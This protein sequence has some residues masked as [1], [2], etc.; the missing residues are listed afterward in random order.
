LPLKLEQT[1][2]VAGPRDIAEAIRLHEVAELGVDDQT[3]GDEIRLELQIARREAGVHKLPLQVLIGA[4]LPRLDPVVDTGVV[5][6]VAD[7]PDGPEIQGTVAV[8]A[9]PGRRV[10]RQLVLPCHVA[11]LHAA[12]N[13]LLGRLTTRTPPPSRRAGW[14][15]VAA[16]RPRT[17]GSCPQIPRRAHERGRCGARPGPRRRSAAPPREE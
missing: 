10:L 14:T 16:R 8:D 13:V 5:H 12:K 3:A 11:T 6:V 7:R 2:T 1:S 4:P 9:P 15:G 17:R